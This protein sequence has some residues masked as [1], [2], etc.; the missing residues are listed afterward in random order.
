MGRVGQVRL[1]KAQSVRRLTA[2]PMESEQLERKST[3]S[4]ATRFTKTTFE[5]RSKTL[6]IFEVLK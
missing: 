5:I 4:R 3:T 1:L 2:R 6:T